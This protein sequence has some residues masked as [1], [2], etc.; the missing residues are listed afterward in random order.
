MSHRELSVFLQNQIFKKST[1][2]KGKFAPFLE[3]VDNEP[4]I[5]KIKD[6]FDL[7]EKLKNLYLFIVKNYLKQPKERY[8]LA[9]L[10]SFS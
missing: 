8:F 9:I 1:K 6:I 3:K 7:S 4:R 2:L 10:F 5:L